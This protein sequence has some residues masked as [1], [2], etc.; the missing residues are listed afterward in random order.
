MAEIV[1]SFPKKAQPFRIEDPDDGFPR[2]NDRFWGDYDEIIAVALGV[3]PVSIIDDDNIVHLKEDD[4]HYTVQQVSE[5]LKRANVSLYY[6]PYYD[7]EDKSVV[8]F[9]EDTRV[10]AVIMLYLDK[11]TVGM[12]RCIIRGILLGYTKEDICAWFMVDILKKMYFVKEFD[13]QRSRIIRKDGAIAVKDAYKKDFDSIYMGC[14]KMLPILI[15]RALDM[16]AKTKR[17][18]KACRIGVD[19]K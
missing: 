18:E 13:K 12:K 5:V 11:I 9:R 8:V 4:D 2:A 10:Y 17:F 19:S 7:D 16:E 3:K 6:V 1:A 15:E 14:T